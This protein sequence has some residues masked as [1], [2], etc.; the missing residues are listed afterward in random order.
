M[1]DTGS[2]EHVR[3]PH[4]LPRRV[5][6]DQPRSVIRDISGNVI[7]NFGASSVN[8]KLGGMDDEASCR[9]TLQ[10]GAVTKKCSLIW[11]DD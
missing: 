5:T 6:L 7:N 1:I 11:Q 2:E 3:G 8:M 9:V 10:G 4:F